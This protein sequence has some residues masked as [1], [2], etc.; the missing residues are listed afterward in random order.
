VTDRRQ[1][2]CE[3]LPLEQL[4]HEGRMQPAAVLGDEHLARFGP[5][6]LPGQP[7]GQLLLA[8]VTVAAPSGMVCLLLSDFGSSSKAP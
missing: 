7:V 4:G 3:C 8:C 1:G 5:G 2:D 6:F